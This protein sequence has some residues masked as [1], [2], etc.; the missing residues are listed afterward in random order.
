M[1]P[2]L[3]GA[4]DMNY[5]RLN[6]IS[7]WLLIPSFILILLSTLTDEGIRN[8]GWTIYPPLSNIIYHNGISVDL[9]ILALHLA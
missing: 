9:L 8:L 1:I 5:P 3:I 6:N 7:F 2:I 4:P